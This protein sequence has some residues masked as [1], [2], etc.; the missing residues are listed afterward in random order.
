MGD[1]NL[2]QYSFLKGTCILFLHC[3]LYYQVSCCVNTAVLL[4]DPTW[5]E[6]LFH[7]KEK[8][9]KTTVAFCSTPPRDKHG[10]LFHTL[11]LIFG[12]S[13]G[14]LVQLKRECGT[15]VSPCLQYHPCTHIPKCYYLGLESLNKVLNFWDHWERL[16]C[17]Q[18]TSSF[19][20]YGMRT[21]L[22]DV[23]V[24]IS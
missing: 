9:I 1:W 15:L 24:L 10:S 12:R 11:C 7:I 22:H 19:L 13:T 8:Y 6:G 23:F 2:K 14:T 3:L 17:W 16:M 4:V 20:I 21:L 18:T 5:M